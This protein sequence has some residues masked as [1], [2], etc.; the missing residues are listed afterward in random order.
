MSQQVVDFI[1]QRFFAVH[2][3]IAPV[4]YGSFMSR[5]RAA[6]QGAALGYRRASEGRLFLE[7]YLDEPIEQV[8]QQRLGMEVERARVVEIGGLA[9]NSSAALV[10]LWNS[11]VCELGDDTDIGVAVLIRPL[12][13][14]F[15]RLGITVHELAPARAERLGTLGT[16]WGSYYENDPIVCAGSLIEARTQFAGFLARRRTAAVA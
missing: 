10:G 4:N 5:M 1:R 16:Q 3:A 12:R 11:A 2:G 6:D 14:M 7:S 8:L 9:S 15:R 13:A